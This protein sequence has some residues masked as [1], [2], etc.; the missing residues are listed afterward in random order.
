MMYLVG[1]LEFQPQWTSSTKLH[2]DSLK[3]Q[4]IS[5]LSMTYYMHLPIPAVVGS[6]GG[7]RFFTC[8]N[9]STKMTAFGDFASII[10]D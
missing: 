6:S 8:L 4:I 3:I 9:S 2:E 1:P 7:G 10:G 5:M